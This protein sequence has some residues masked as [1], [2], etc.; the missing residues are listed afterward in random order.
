MKD[1]FLNLKLIFSPIKLLLCI[2]IT[3]IM[4]LIVKSMSMYEFYASCASYISIIGIIVFAEIPLID[5]KS[6]LDE[7]IYLAQNKAWKTYF[8]RILA[9][10]LGISVLVLLSGYVFVLKISYKNILIGYDI[11]SQLL[12]L[13]NVLPYILLLGSISMTLSNVFRSVYFGYI[14]ASIYWLINVFYRKTYI[15]LKIGE[16]NSLIYILI[17]SFILIIVNQY[18]DSIKPVKRG[19]L[20]KM[21]HI[22]EIKESLSSVAREYNLISEEEY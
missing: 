4:P 7:I 2:L 22:E 13:I 14:I 10:I 15:I 8:I 18:L 12:L 1:I 19:Q 6:G 21:L 17:I 20:I 5:V 16:N 3:A 11:K 9:A